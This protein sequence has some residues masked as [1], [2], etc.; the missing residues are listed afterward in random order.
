[1]M[2]SDLFDKLE[3]LARKVRKNQKPFGNIQLVLAGDFC[4]LPAVEKNKKSS[5]CFEAKT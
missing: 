1:M 2:S 5:Y 3:S 4:Q